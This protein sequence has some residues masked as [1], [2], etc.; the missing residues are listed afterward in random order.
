M[1]T[2]A[3]A[4]SQIEEV[5]S[6]VNCLYRRS[7]L[8]LVNGIA[9]AE[10]LLSTHRVLP[11]PGSRY[12]D[13]VSSRSMLISSGVGWSGRDTLNLAAMMTRR[14]LAAMSAVDGWALV[15]YQGARAW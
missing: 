4:S 3:F 12:S 11:R 6:L 14:S 13:L 1:H 7:P 8:H 2:Q 15:A 10:I 9:T 5:T